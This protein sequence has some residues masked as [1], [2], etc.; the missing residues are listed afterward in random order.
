MFLRLLVKGAD[1]VPSCRATIGVNVTC[2]EETH[3]PYRYSLSSICVH[4]VIHIECRLCG[5]HENDQSICRD[6]AEKHPVTEIVNELSEPLT[7][8]E[9]D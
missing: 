6:G 9:Y 4:L 7:M 5:G 2:F 8:G 3:E 1:R